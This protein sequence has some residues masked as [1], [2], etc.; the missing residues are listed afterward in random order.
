M[1]KPSPIRLPH[2]LEKEAEDSRLQ[3]IQERIANDRKNGVLLTSMIEFLQRF[4]IK[5]VEFNH[6]MQLYIPYPTISQMT[7]DSV[8][9]KLRALND[10]Y[11]SYSGS[12]PHPLICECM[13]YDTSDDSELHILYKRL[14]DL[15]ARLNNNVLC[16]SNKQ[17][18]FIAKRKSK[19]EHYDWNE[20]DWT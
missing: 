3:A 5:V 2:E 1:Q 16:I 10:F 6:Y 9:N 14:G 4:E 20:Y 15:I 12:N 11:F 7:K 19:E 8:R 17:I 13:A 18:L